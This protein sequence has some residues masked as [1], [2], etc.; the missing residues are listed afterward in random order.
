MVGG[1]IKY[2][3]S[4]N[5]RRVEY[6]SESGG[7]S[8]SYFRFFDSKELNDFKEALKKSQFKHSSDGVYSSGNH[9]I[10]IEGNKV[11]FDFDW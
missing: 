3:R 6:V 8:D 4:F 9:W 7:S 11:R 5:G 2:T 1:E 10:K